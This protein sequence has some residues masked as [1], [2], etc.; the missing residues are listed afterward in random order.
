[1]SNTTM[2]TDTP[3]PAPAV[4]RGDSADSIRRARETARAFA[5]GLTPAPDPSLADTLVL[6]VS[7]LATNALRHGGGRYTLELSADPNTVT[8]A[9]SDLSPAPP[10]ERTPDLNGD[11]GGFGWHMIR[12]LAGHLAISPGPGRGKT[13]HA[14]LPRQLALAESTGN[15]RTAGAA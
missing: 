2:I 5:V 8:A 9:V 3:T 12:H 14:Q 7:E 11:T 4:V 6:M 1:M 10:R 13:I 15:A